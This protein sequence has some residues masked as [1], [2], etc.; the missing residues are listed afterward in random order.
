MEA[1]GFVPPQMR[2]TPAQ[3]QLHDDYHHA[4]CDCC[5]FPI[6]GVRFKCLN[7]PD[8]DICASCEQDGQ[9]SA[10]PPAH[11][12][13]VLPRP[14][15][16]ALAA[17]WKHHFPA[18]LCVDEVGTGTVHRGAFCTQC[19]APVVGAR[20][21]CVNCP[22]M[23]CLCEGCFSGRAPID[24]HVNGRNHVMLKIPFAPSPY[25]PM[26]E[27]NS[28]GEYQCG[29]HVDASLFQT[30]DGMSGALSPD[31]GALVKSPLEGDVRVP[32]LPVVYAGDAAVNPLSRSA[33]RREQLAEAEVGQRK[34][35]ATGEAA[36]VHIREMTF[37]DVDD[38][39]L[40][41]ETESFS[42]PFEREYFV[43]ILERGHYFAWVAEVNGAV[44]GYIALRIRRGWTDIQSL[45]V[46]SKARGCGVGRQLMERALSL[47]DAYETNV[48]LHV[49]VWNVCALALYKSLGFV[50]AKWLFDY[51]QRDEEDA[52][53][54]YIERQKK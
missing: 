6:L 54:M 16:E 48:R 39:V 17:A 15:P 31:R 40:A 9:H 42:Q 29:M 19:K 8:F 7:C 11:L 38:S 3:Q 34:R 26:E 46:S 33:E 10:H 27:S 4:I 45:A 47:A 36:P 21:V 13:L 2:E 35:R 51:Y 32:L 37:A 20:F 28:S 1:A 23:F 53:E 41:I 30:P 52:I 12:F 50:A 24:K 14:V 25:V 44:V 22:S 18:P 43:N 49:S 5:D